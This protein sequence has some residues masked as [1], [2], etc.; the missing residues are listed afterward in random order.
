[1]ADDILLELKN[2]YN[3]YRGTALYF[4]TPL[5]QLGSTISEIERLRA[6]IT[7]LEAGPQWQPIETAPKDGTVFLVYND[8]SGEI[9]ITGWTRNPYGAMNLFGADD[10]AMW[11]PLPKP[12]ENP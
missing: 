12:P 6:R 8:R 2:V 4:L 10:N 1:M 3:R 7:E 5:E 11:M 9:S